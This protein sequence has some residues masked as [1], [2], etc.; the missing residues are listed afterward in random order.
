MHGLVEADF[1]QVPG[2]AWG[3]ML[4]KTAAARQTWRRVN[5]RS[6]PQAVAEQ[7]REEILSGWLK[8]GERLIEQKLASELG[9]GQPTMREALKELENQGFVRKVPNKGTYVTNLSSDDLNK[10]LEVRICLES[11]AI[12]HAAR[13]ASEADL[14]ELDDIVR[15]MDS[16]VK[17]VN[18]GSFQKAD[19]EFHRRIWHVSGNEYIGMALERVLFGLLAFGLVGQRGADTGLREAV[20]T[21]K[22]ILEALRSRDPEQARAVFIKAIVEDWKKSRQVE[23]DLSAV[24]SAP[25]IHRRAAKRSRASLRTTNKSAPL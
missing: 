12:Y 13:N 4:H 19:V 25:S 16:A 24:A 17:A 2:P 6:L 8:P 11:V 9:I 18:L 22:Q 14:A 7:L 10:I 21:H 3:W 23:V 1:F 15:T 5:F 20:E